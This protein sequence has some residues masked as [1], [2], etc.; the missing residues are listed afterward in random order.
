MLEAIATI[1]RYM[2]TPQ[3]R[4]ILFPH[5]EMIKRDSQQAISE[6]L[7]KKDID[8]RYVTI[9]KELLVK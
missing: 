4:E 7:D 2:S 9:K 1:A 6:E 3:E 5:A 8:K